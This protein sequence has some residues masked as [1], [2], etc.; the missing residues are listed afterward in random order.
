MDH[1]FY[2]RIC[3]DITTKP[4]STPFLEEKTEIQED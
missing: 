4:L 3:A 1:F 2:A